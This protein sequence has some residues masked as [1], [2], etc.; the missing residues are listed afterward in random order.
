[1]AAGALLSQQKRL[2]HGHSPRPPRCSVGG[3]GRSIEPG[4]DGAVAG[5]AARQLAWS[6][7]EGRLAP[8]IAVAARKQACRREAGRPPL[9]EGRARPLSARRGRTS[10]TAADLSL[11]GCL[12]VG[13]CPSLTGAGTDFCR[14]ARRW[15]ACCPVVHVMA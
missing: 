11:T 1:M 7:G 9:S 2:A 15:D 5:P 8:V 3:R 12:V 10:P 13:A 4:V 6:L 14:Q